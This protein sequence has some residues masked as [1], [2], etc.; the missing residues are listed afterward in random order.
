MTQGQPNM[1]IWPPQWPPVHVIAAPPQQSSYEQNWP[2]CVHVSPKRGLGDGQF[3]PAGEAHH[4]VSD[5]VGIGGGPP[6]PVV[7]KHS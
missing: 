7:Q 1:S 5:P 6:Q 4:H 2:S 3:G